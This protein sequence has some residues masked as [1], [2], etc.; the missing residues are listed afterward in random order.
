MTATHKD[1]AVGLA[2]TYC[3]DRKAWAESAQSFT[4]WQQATIEITCHDHSIIVCSRHIHMIVI[5]HP[6]PV[7][8]E[9][10][11]QRNANG[12]V[13]TTSPPF[14]N[15]PHRSHVLFAKAAPGMTLTSWSQHHFVDVSRSA[16]M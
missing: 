6:H 5:L 11:I 2:E 10:H 7:R 9:S 13:A 14:Y 8:G 4:L 1:N 12:E 15:K 16:N 3:C